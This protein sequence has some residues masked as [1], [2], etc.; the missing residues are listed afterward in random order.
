MGSAQSRHVITNL[1]NSQIEYI[2]AVYR[3]AAA[4]KLC[5]KLMQ[6]IYNITSGSSVEEFLCTVDKLIAGSA[7]TACQLCN[8]YCGLKA[9][10]HIN[11]K[12]TTKG[13]LNAVDQPRAL[14]ND[15]LAFIRL[16]LSESAPTI[17][18]SYKNFT[19]IQ[20]A[21]IDR[22]L[23]SIIHHCDYD[24]T[25][26]RHE[27]F[28]DCYAKSR[29]LQRLWKLLFTWAFSIDAVVPE[30]TTAITGI[31]T[32]VTK[33]ISARSKLVDAF[34][35]FT[36]ECHLPTLPDWKLLYASKTHGKSWTVFMKSLPLAQKSLLVFRDTDGHVFGAYSNVVLKHDPKFTG[37]SSCFLLSI[38]PS[39]RVYTASG[40]N[41]NYIYYNSGQKTLLNGLGFGGQVFN[42]N[43]GFLN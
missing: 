30:S 39:L 4:P 7:S 2:S 20:L 29:P 18:H 38:S 21:D 14:S 27:S 11:G 17:E 32:K 6:A 33:P 34:T 9:G 31:N 1:S 28:I 35:A 41:S 5:E 43:Q 26:M 13:A 8:A 3:K 19:K 15:V 23:D 36:I 16:L 25:L 37:D 24:G 12:A 10:S 22:M 42:S 40:I